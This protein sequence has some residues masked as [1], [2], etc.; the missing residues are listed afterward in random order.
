M[1]MRE[2]VICE[3]ARTSIGRYG[4]MFKSQNAVDLGVAAL[5]GLLDRAGIPPES[6]GHPVGATGGTSQ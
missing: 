5:K 6:L 2:A 3:P 4:G 1:S